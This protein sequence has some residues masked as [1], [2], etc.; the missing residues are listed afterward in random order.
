MSVGI[1]H[2]D[3]IIL[4]TTDGGKTWQVQLNKTFSDYYESL[5]INFINAKTGW[6]LTCDYDTNDGDLYYTSNA[7]K[8][9]EVISQFHCN[10]PSPRELVFITPE[11]GWIPLEMGAGGL[12]GGFMYTG[13]G[14]KTVSQKID[15]SGIENVEGCE[16]V[17][18]K[19]GWAV[20]L[21]D[22]AGDYIT[23]TVDSGATWNK[24]Y[25]N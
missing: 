7:G 16:F 8:D 5:D 12:V 21:D 11:V 1:L 22:K 13:N 9:W 3:F 20:V 15:N 14:G 2:Y 10:R 25:P 4:N 19:E 6:F 18:L 24:V 17:S 23:H